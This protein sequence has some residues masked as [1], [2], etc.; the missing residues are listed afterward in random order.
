M[1][2][3]DAEAIR[4]PAY[5][6]LEL[7]VKGVRLDDAARSQAEVF[8]P[9]AQPS[10]Q[11][12]E[13]E[14]IL[15]EDVWVSAPIDE[16]VASSSP[17]LLRAEGEQWSLQRDGWQ[18]DARL[19]PQ[20]DFYQR[21]TSRGTPMWKLATVHGSFISVQ[22]ESAC[23]Y[24]LLGS[25]CSFCRHGSVESSSE[26]DRAEVDE[27]T[28]VVHAA[29]AEGVAEFVYFNAAY[30]DSDDAG[31]RRLEPFVR[32]VKAHVDTAVAVQC[33]PPRTNAWIDQTYAM[34]VDALSYNIEI[35]DADILE[36]HVPGRVR[37]I[38]RGR[39]YEALAHAATIFPSGTV[40]SNLALGVEPVESTLRGID[41]LTEI[42]VLPV[43]CAP[44]GGS[45]SDATP[46]APVSLQDVTR[47]C[48]HLFHAVRDAKINMG[49]VR[50]LSFAITP[51]E[52]RF[53]AGDDARVAVAMQQFY[54]SRI[55][56]MTARNLA[57]LRRRLRVRR[58]SDSFDSSGL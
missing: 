46:A 55:G 12:R 19:V 21:R 43:L 38:G 25:P 15:A 54:R 8:R 28:E 56:T 33:H 14:L 17:F 45:D 4:N 27:V 20:P 29:F 3:P 30:T 35:H 7:T 1:T 10:G 42:G 32:S 11:A 40:W 52:A 36:A 23:G 16:G 22:P 9:P 6:K 41:R 13:I 26:P 24:S 47:I 53:F 37:K 51:L 34:G 58:V 31:I 39:Y 50:D 18:V 48:T 44:R 2:A 57:R 5:L 49:W